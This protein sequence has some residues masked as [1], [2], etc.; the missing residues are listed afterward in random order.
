MTEQT[1]K[2]G[3]GLGGTMI[4]HGDD[5]LFE[6]SQ[7]L[8]D[9][10]C[11]YCEL[12]VNVCACEDAS[13]YDFDWRDIRIADDQLHDLLQMLLHDE[14]SSIV[15]WD[16]ALGVSLALWAVLGGGAWALT[17]LLI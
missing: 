13:D 12:P 6:V 3:D 2:I 8:G 11:V 1:Y 9:G 5:N 14:R 10:F 16:I 4:V 7:E 17:N 15:R